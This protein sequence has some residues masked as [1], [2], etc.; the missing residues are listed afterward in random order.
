MRYANSVLGITVQALFQFICYFGS[1]ILSR[2]KNPTKRFLTSC[3]EHSKETKL[4]GPKG[5]PTARGTHCGDGAV[6]PEPGQ[7]EHTAAGAG[8]HPAPTVSCSPIPGSQRVGGTQLVLTAAWLT[9]GH[10]F[11]R[12]SS[13]RSGAHHENAK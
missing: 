7:E 4:L 2:G 5:V 3:P 13:Q 11:A 10:R 12:A 6:R 9:Q 8:P 1:F